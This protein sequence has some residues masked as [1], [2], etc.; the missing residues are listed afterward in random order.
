MTPEQIKADKERVIG[1]MPVTVVIGSKT[2][3]GRRSQMKWTRKYTENGLNDLYQFSVSISTTDAIAVDDR[4]TVSGTTY[5]I[6]DVDIGSVIS[7]KIIHLGDE[8][9]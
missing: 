7:N 3:T 6:V 5:R 2:Y 4:A 9:Q 1:Y 8:Y